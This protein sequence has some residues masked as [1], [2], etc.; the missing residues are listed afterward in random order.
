[1]RSVGRTNNLRCKHTIFQKYKSQTDRNTPKQLRISPTA[2]THPENVRSN[3]DSA[4]HCHVR[5]H[6]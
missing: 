6:Q 1:M 4:R 3:S 2:V 5:L